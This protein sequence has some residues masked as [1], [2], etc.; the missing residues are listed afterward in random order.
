MTVFDVRFRTTIE[1]EG[2]LEATRL[3][4][5][6]AE[7]IGGRNGIVVTTTVLLDNGEFGTGIT[8]LIPPP[9]MRPVE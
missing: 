9:N 7:R 1:T 5:A 3:V 2:I 6:A 4:K 8:T